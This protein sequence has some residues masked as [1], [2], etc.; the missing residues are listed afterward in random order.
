M[1]E[2]LCSLMIF[3]AND[4]WYKSIILQPSKLPYIQD[5]NPLGVLL[6]SRVPQM[7]VRG[8]GG[9]KVDSWAC[10]AADF[11]KWYAGCGVWRVP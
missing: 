1:V 2:D 9:N 8:L 5:D 4:W 7:Q 10:V 3:W 6:P 11:S